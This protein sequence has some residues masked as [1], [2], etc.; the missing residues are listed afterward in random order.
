MLIIAKVADIE[1][2]ETDIVREE[3][4]LCPITDMQRPGKSSILKRL[5]DSCLLYYE[6]L[7]QGFSAAQEEYDEELLY[8]LDQMDY[9]ASL[10]PPSENETRAMEARVTRTVVVRK[11]IHQMQSD[12][13]KFSIDELRA[14][15]EDQ[16]ELFTSPEQVRVSHILIR[17]Q[18]ENAAAK[19]KEVRLKIHTHE[20]FNCAI[21]DCSDCPSH[22][23]CGDLGYFSRGKMHPSIE[24]MA[25]SLQVG[26]ISEVFTSP[27]GYHILM[28]TDRKA[29]YILP[30]EE[31]KDIL[32]ARLM[33]LEREYYLAKHIKELREKYQ[34]LI[35]ILSEDYM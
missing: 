34:N 24:E 4:E 2:L 10:M 20:D 13:P 16:K 35:Q 3:K 18:K 12:A 29:P 7:S 32:R 15:Y 25:F 23:Q 9:H 21:A 28:L 11:Y 1:I 17:K 8:T 14:F 33:A 6:A 22:L 26:E 27:F 5:I 19:A 30:F 31:V